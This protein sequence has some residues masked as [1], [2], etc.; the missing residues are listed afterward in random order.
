MT[1]PT[2]IAVGYLFVKSLEFS[3][4]IP[5][6][7]A[8]DYILWSVITANGPDFDVLNLRK[9]KNHRQ[10]SLLHVPSVWLMAFLIA[11][12]LIRLTGHSELTTYLSIAFFNV[13][14][15]FILDSV[16]A[17]T[18]I[19]WLAPFSQRQ[20]N[21]RKTAAPQ[22][23][24]NVWRY[25]WYYIKQPAMVLEILVWFAAAF[26]WFHSVPRFATP[27]QAKTTSTRRYRISDIIR[28]KTPRFLIKSRSK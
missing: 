20:Y 7:E 1:T 16:D 5:H 15:H 27:I 10:N 8:A 22:C 26:I 6:N 12:A 28:L 13:F 19:A 4:L 21:I 3:R 9:A 23:I 25:C 11:Y 17:S 24:Y 2:H 18:G 14:G